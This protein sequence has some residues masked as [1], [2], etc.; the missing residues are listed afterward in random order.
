[1]EPILYLVHRIPYPPNKGDKVRSFN[2]LK[3]LASR[4][5]VHLGTFVDDPNDMAYLEPLR[6]CCASLAAMEINP[7][8]AR[9]RSLAGFWTGEA[10][11]LP[12][13]RDASLE[14][15][16]RTV[17]REQGIRK[18]VVF[19]SAMAQY[20]SSLEGLRVVVDFVDVDS[21]KWDAL[22][23]ARRWPMSAVYRREGERLL[24]FERVVARQAD[25]S[26][27]VTAAEAELFRKRAPE[28]AARVCHAANGVDATYFAPNP[29]LPSPFARDDE[30]IVFTGA[31]DYW[32]NID[33]VTWFAQEILPPILAER[34]RARFCVVG[35]SPS[36]AVQALARDPHVV[37]T[38]RVP[39]VR[40]YLQH[41]RV[42]VAPLRVAR[43]IQNKA[44]EAMAMAR[45]VVIT[46][47]AAAALSAVP[48]T[49]LETAGNATEFSRR[50]L[51]MMD[52]ACGGPVG[53]AA[54][55]RIEA[56]YDWTTNL[57]PFDALLRAPE[58]ARSMTG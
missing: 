9:V 2:L 5:R 53:H 28:C 6:E 16:V 40:P 23:R 39:D 43:G 38:G 55:A 42:V 10:L 36:P 46:S 49:E 30:P 12:Y 35:M 29:D 37:V 48:G 18:A 1:V 44:L 24:A 19:S 15:W 22:G 51:A 56:D 17:V 32:P 58:A 41:A 33:A 31:M 7:T 4:Y 45:P 21:A 27:F 11:T 8:A 57:A 20:V 50:T 54:R 52:P 3:F 13:Y 26:V 47:G 25:A 34:P 14:A